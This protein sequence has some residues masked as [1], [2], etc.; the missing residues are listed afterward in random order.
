VGVPPAVAARI[1]YLSLPAA[2]DNY[3]LPEWMDV[4]SGMF[5]KLESLYFVRDNNPRA[6][7]EALRMRRL[8]ILYRLP[9]LVSIDGR[10]VTSVEREL[11]RP[12]SP[13]GYR[14]NRGDWIRED[15][16]SSSDASTS[17][18]SE[19]EIQHGDAVEVSLQGI[20]RL[21][22]V[23]P[24]KDDNIRVS[25]TQKSA[26]QQQERHQSPPLL[27]HTKSME[28]AIRES[29]KQSCLSPIGSILSDS[30][31]EPFPMPCG[32]SA[33]IRHVDETDTTLAHA[34]D[35][36][37][38]QM[39]DAINLYRSRSLSASSQRELQENGNP[40]D[41]SPPKWA[42]ATYDRSLPSPFPM[43]FRSKSFNATYPVP[44]RTASSSHLYRRHS[45][46]ALNR[47]FAK[48]T[49]EQ[50][51]SVEIPFSPRRSSPRFLKTDRP[52][53]VPG[54]RR[55]PPMKLNGS[56]ESKPKRRMGRWR[57]KIK[58]RNTSIIS[59]ND[60]DD[61]DDTSSDEEDELIVTT[62]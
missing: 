48:A 5:F 4:V 13:S 30:E 61:E 31:L 22:D 55:T 15:E 27:N 42:Q 57:A 46:D 58:A 49:I 10:K 9:D 1:K 62:T 26:A 33:A 14:V 38:V 17:S 41:V 54:A 16:D 36:S 52:P 35:D 2:S 39:A 60:E 34:D 59:I 6:A 7:M 3:S 11:A 12:S 47:D 43:Q 18:S 44:P 40:Q 28:P 8:Y 20:I 24:P 19:G 51:Q 23:E 50:Q 32:G 53:P 45:S 21:V 25:K 29:T 37:S 56:S